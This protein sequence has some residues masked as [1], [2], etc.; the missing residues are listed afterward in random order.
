[1]GD[2]VDAITF[3][4]IP[5]DMLI[6]TQS[7]DFNVDTLLRYYINGKLNSP[8]DPFTRQ[9]L[10]DADKYKVLT[11]RTTQIINVRVAT[12][13][14]KYSTFQVYK[15]NKV[16][17]MIA[18]IL[19]EVI[20][21]NLNMYDLFSYDFLVTDATGDYTFRS[22]YD[23]QMENELPFSGNVTVD[24]VRLLPRKRI[25]HCRIMRGFTSNR[26]YESGANYLAIYHHCNQVVSRIM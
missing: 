18:H 17:E 14:R 19:T 15:F 22:L 12:C 21:D 6:T 2:T 4:P 7:G 20:I 3:E 24:L 8:S 5:S 23:L 1:M 26:V 16:G 10:S 11:Y 13:S 25:E 9:P